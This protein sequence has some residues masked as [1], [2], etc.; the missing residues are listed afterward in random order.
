MCD[1]TKLSV[2]YKTHTI[3]FFL[4]RKIDIKKIEKIKNN[5]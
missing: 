5:I 3:F 1:F 4:T 2:I